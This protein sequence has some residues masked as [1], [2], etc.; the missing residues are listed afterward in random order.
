MQNV[1]P[2]AELWW[3]KKGKYLPSLK[4]G[5]I[6]DKASRSEAVM[7]YVENHIEDL[8][9]FL[10]DDAQRELKAKEKA[11]REKQ[12][13]L[14]KMASKQTRRRIQRGGRA[15]RMAGQ[16]RARETIDARRRRFF[17]DAPF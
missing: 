7:H 11:E 9:M 8:M 13:I 2:Q 10:E 17:E 16:S 3:E 4:P 15:G 1:F 5:K 14:A 6:P 12:K